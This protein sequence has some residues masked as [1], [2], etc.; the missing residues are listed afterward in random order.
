MIDLRSSAEVRAA[1]AVQHSALHDGVLMQRAATALAIACAGLLKDARGAVVGSQVVVLA[2]SGDNGGDALFAAAA[3]AARGCGVDAILVSERAHAAG[4]AAFQRAGGVVYRG[5]STPAGIIERADLVLDGITGIGGSGG[6]RPEAA[7]L[8]ELVAASGA[9]LVAVDVPSG[10]DAD[11]GAVSGA[12][13]LAD[14]TVTFGAVKP[15]LVLA[16]GAQHSGAVL[17]VDIGLEFDTSSLVRSL[18]SIDVAGWV[19]EPAADAYKYRRGVVGVVAGSAAYPGAALLA[20]A[21]ARRGNVG[22]VRFLDRADGVAPMVVSHFPDLVVDG[23]P[24][25]DQER[26]GAWACGPGFTGDAVDTLTVKAVLAAAVPVVLDAGALAV[27]AAD[28]DVRELIGARA[29]R[30]LVTVLTPHEG[31]FARLQPGLLADAGGRLT[32]ARRAA[33]A[34]QAI[35]VLKGP[36]T[37]IAA[38]GGAC[39]IDTEGTA[40]LG[41]AGSGDVLTGLVGALLASAWA[42]GQ[43]ESDDLLEATAAAVWLHG[44]AGRIAAGHSVVVATDIADAISA[45]IILARFGREASS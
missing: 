36:G 44:A 33:A 40:D 12:A 7:R 31:E 42:N 26:V 5:D 20:A 19:A 17:L 9:V 30:K 1:E 28:A 6:L 15:G 38:P 13:I 18:E 37:I 8:A 45:S 23:S 32:A 3:L 43:R 10:I 41:T 22:M 14:V 27:V 25:A 11:S 34:L 24:P 16:P 29:A 21:A 39:F 2:G 4:L 35:V